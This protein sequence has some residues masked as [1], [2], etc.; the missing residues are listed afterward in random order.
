M[1]GSGK[2]MKVRITQPIRR[3]IPSRCFLLVTF[4]IAVVASAS[5]ASAQFAGPAVTSP[6]VAAGVS[7]TAA[8][9]DFPAVRIEPGDI[10]SISTVGVPELTTTSLTSSGSIAPTTGGGFVQGIK[11][12]ADGEIALPYLGSVKIAGLTPSQA[13]KFLAASLEK[14]GFLVDPEISVQ[15]VD[16]PTRAITVLGEV[17]KP[18]PI[19][20]FG[21]IRLLDALSACG[22]LTPFAS[23]TITIRRPGQSDPITVELGTDP[24]TANA[25]DVPLM[26]GDTVIVSKVGSVFVLGYV[27]TPQAIP[28]SG[29]SPVT[30]LRAL[31]MAG[32]INYGA[33]LSKARIIRTTADNQQVEIRLD[34]KKIMFG[35]QQDVTLVS[36][37]ILLVPSN[38][39]KAG[40][41]AAGVGLLSSVIYGAVETAA[42]LK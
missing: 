10:I 21:H 17:L 38:A 2:E 4:A 36:N 1:T 22:G 23:H 18:S 8:T 28:L 34:L 5:S 29:N 20:A 19:P 24:K 31:T 12:G 16:S 33:G 39:F 14:G 3:L 6:P 25:A 35:K 7:T 30:V 41:A 37:D 13:G 40:M 15:L 27:K 9:S 26:A 42:V 32:G 11:V